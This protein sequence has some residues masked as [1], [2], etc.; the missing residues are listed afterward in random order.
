VYGFS[1][2][3]LDRGVWAL[4]TGEN[5]GIRG[6][7]R[8]TTSNTQI[9]LFNCSS[10][11]SDASEKFISSSI[12]LSYQVGGRHGFKVN[13]I[14]DINLATVNSSVVAFAYFDG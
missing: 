7:T 14:F 9:S 6:T 8:P 5:T 12:L 11:I 3:V 13:S 1:H 2:T 10:P 4:A